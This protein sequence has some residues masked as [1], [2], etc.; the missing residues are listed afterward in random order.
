MRQD[1][2]LTRVVVPPREWVEEEEHMEE[3][4]EW[5]PLPLPRPPHD[6]GLGGLLGRD[7]VSGD[8]EEGGGVRDSPMYCG[9]DVRTGYDDDATPNGSSSAALK[10]LVLWRF[11]ELAMALMSAL[12][13]PSSSFFPLL[14][15]SRKPFSKTRVRREH[16]IHFDSS[17]TIMLL[18]YINSGEIS[19]C[20]LR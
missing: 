1:R 5:R 6:R 10:A 15:L 3:V 9:V 20:L 7:S 13:H 19:N 11:A 14:S 16:F 18:S 12:F 8:R 2:G 4:G 17:I